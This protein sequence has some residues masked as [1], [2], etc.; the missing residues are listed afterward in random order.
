SSTIPIIP[1]ISVTFGMILNDPDNTIYD[2]PQ[3]RFEAMRRTLVEELNTIKDKNTKA[4]NEQRKRILDG[5]AVI[6]K[7]LETVKDKDNLYQ[8]IWNT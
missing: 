4:A 8:F 1:V 5:I 7:L 6:D 2:P 3:Q